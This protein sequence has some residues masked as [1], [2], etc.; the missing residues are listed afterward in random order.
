LALP[1]RDFRAL[2]ARF[3]RIGLSIRIDNL[4]WS[5]IIALSLDAL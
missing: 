5:R 3:S 1:V 2:S 4:T